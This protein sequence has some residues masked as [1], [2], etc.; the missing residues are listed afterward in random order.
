[1]SK[2]KAEQAYMNIAASLPCACCG[3]AAGVELHHAR[4]D[5]GTAMRSGDFSVIPL[6]VPC[7]RGQNGIHGDKTMLRIFKTGEMEMLNWTVG[8]VFKRVARL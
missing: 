4:Q 1:M 8:E 7:H 5:Q 2:T 3:D 6:C